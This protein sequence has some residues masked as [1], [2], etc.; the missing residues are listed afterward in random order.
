LETLAHNLGV[1]IRY[2]NLEGETAI[3]PGGI[4]R[5]RNKRVI[6][7]N[8]KASPRDKVNTLARALRRFDLSQVYIRPA[9]R[10]FLEAFSDETK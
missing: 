8:R 9:L 2:E 3:S 7:V 10:D 6:I 1:Q 4:C 5:I